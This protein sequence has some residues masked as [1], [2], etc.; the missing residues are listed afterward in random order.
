MPTPEIDVT[1]VP[2]PPKRPQ[3][4][5]VDAAAAGVQPSASTITA[6]GSIARNVSVSS[7]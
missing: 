5:L 1:A 3:V 2:R 7:R 4:D 6:S